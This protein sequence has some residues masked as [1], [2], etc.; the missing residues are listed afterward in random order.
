VE[1]LEVADASVVVVMEVA[2]SANPT[3][4]V[5]MKISD[6][7]AQDAADAVETLDIRITPQKLR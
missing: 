1:A 7:A 4:P 6:A 3:E 5:V 2:G